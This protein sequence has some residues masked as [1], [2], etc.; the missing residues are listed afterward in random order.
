MDCE[1]VQKDHVRNVSVALAHPSIVEIV[2]ALSV[3]VLASIA[4]GCVTGVLR[5]GAV[6]GNQLAALF[7]MFYGVLGGALGIVVG[8]LVLTFIH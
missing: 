4:G 8:I 2:V 6:L 3:G 7:G 1:R 5:N